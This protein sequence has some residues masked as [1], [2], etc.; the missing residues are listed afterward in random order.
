MS[1]LLQMALGAHREAVLRRV[2]GGR[3]GPVLL[4]MV[5]GIAAALALSRLLRGQLYAIS[6][7]DP[8]ILRSVM[9]IV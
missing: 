8:F 6:P 5:S 1:S 3:A 7:N 2:L 4:G 9:P